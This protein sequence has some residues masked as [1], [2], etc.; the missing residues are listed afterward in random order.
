MCT[1]QKP[2]KRFDYD[3]YIQG[4]LI[5]KYV[6]IYHD[7]IPDKP[8]IDTTEFQELQPVTQHLIALKPDDGIPELSEV[9]VYPV[10]LN[11]SHLKAATISA[12]NY[13]GLVVYK[14]GGF[15]GAKL[16]FQSS[17]AGPSLILYGK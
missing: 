6:V 8:E 9:N 12:I 2:K 15:A 7:E 17:R 13:Y 16:V 5:G 11:Q 1:I 4:R 10:N 3:A 14:I